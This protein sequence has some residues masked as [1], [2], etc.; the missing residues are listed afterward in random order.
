MKLDERK[1]KE[2]M[3]VVGEEKADE[4]EDEVNI[5]EAR[6]QKPKESSLNKKLR[7]YFNSPFISPIVTVIRE[8]GT[9][10]VF[11]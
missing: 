2:P 10:L 4:K 6:S 11:R 1:M 5:S 8:I 9:T 7:H 3:E